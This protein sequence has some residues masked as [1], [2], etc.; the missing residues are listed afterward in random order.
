MATLIKLK[1]LPFTFFGKTF[2]Q[3]QSELPIK[4]KM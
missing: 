4:I 3:K 2:L 1:K